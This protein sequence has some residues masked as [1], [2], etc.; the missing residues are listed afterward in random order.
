MYDF[1]NVCNL[2]YLFNHA[3]L[4][5]KSNLSLELHYMTLLNNMCCVN[6]DELGWDPGW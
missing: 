6:D 5:L 2:K 3:C 4:E 1:N